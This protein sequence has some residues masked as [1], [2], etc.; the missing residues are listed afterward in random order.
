M[1][2]KRFS[3]SSAGLHLEK[4]IRKNYEMF[5]TK[6]L[7]SLSLVKLHAVQLKKNFSIYFSLKISKNFQEKYTKTFRKITNR[8]SFDEYFY[9]YDL[10]ADIT[11]RSLSK[12]SFS[13]C[14]EQMH[15]AES[16]GRYFSFC[17]LLIRRIHSYPIS[18]RLFDGIWWKRKDG[19]FQND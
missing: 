7:W 1:I 17:P 8:A 4:V 16:F 12:Q 14:F 5:G 2:A 18:F 19:F 15:N 13:K 9:R 10:K 3:S 6:H 11:C